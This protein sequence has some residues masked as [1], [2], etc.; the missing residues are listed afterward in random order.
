MADKQTSDLL[1]SRQKIIDVLM[2]PE[3]YADIVFS[4]GKIVNVI[5]GEIYTAELAVVGAHIARVGDCASPKGLPHEN[6]RV[7]W[8]NHPARAYRCTY[9]F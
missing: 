2:A 3:T 6:R 1:A 4:G 7:E 8:P 9:A 5:S